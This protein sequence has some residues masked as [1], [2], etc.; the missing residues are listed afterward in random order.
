MKLKGWIRQRLEDVQALRLSELPHVMVHHS[1]RS[2]GARID[3]WSST[4]NKKAVCAGPRSKCGRSRRPHCGTRALS[5]VSIPFL[6]S[7]VAWHD[8]HKSHRAERR[9]SESAAPHQGKVNSQTEPQV[10][11]GHRP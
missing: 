3:F 2:K 11:V 7:P 9:S 10:L 4:G 6:L 1:T 5:Q 8:F